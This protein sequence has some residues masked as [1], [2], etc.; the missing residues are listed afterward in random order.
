[1]LTS[2]NLESLAKFEK[3]ARNSFK[4]VPME[5]VKTNG[6]MWYHILHCE[7]PFTSSGFILIHSGSQGSQ[8]SQG[9]VPSHVTDDDKCLF[10]EPRRKEQ[11]RARSKSTEKMASLLGR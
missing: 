7:C 5:K 2:T 6:T 11:P 9:F 1:M 4:D 8:G 3:Q 10:P